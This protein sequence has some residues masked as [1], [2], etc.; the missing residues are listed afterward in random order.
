[1]R[2][3]AEEHKVSFSVLYGKN[4]GKEKYSGNMIKISDDKRY[5]VIE[6]GK[7]LDA[8]QNILI[9][10]GGDLY[11]KVLSN[12]GRKSTVCFT[13]KP[14]CFTEWVKTIF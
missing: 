14:D 11:A 10:I 13:S 5:A 8:M 4:V 6:T 1:M 12:D 7:T 9:D 2:D 3:I